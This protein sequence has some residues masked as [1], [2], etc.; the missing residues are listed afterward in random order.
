MYFLQ[1]L[2]SNKKCY[3]KYR[4]ITKIYVTP[5]VAQYEHGS[6]DRLAHQHLTFNE[7]HNLEILEVN[8]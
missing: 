7:M 1:R 3:V 6:S 4:E 8:Q 5:N 2:T